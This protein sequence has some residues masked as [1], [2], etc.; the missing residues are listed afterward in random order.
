MPGLKN[1]QSQEMVPSSADAPQA[2]ISTHGPFLFEILFLILATYNG[3]G[4][5]CQ[6]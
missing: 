4:C 2:A 6:Q 1:A 3:I 5:S